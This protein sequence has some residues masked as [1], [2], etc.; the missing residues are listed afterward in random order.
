MDWARDIAIEEEFIQRLRDKYLDDR[1]GEYHYTAMHACLT[2]AYFDETDPIP[3]TRQ[4]LMFFSIGFALEQVYLR[5]DK[6]PLPKKRDVLGV[7]MSPDYTMVS[8]KDAELDLKTTRMGAEDDG[9][10]KRNKTR[11]GGWPDYWLRQFAGYSVGQILEGQGYNKDNWESFIPSYW[12][13]HVGIVYLGFPAQFVAGTLRFTRDELIQHMSRA[14]LRRDMLQMFLEQREVPTP[15]T[16]NNGDAECNAK[17]D[18]PCRYLMR[19]QGIAR[20]EQ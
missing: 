8:L 4:Q 18:S 3:L 15:F 1:R 11:P 10:P 7:M 9:S 5:D 2:K 20:E 17:G 6:T 12:D 19:C 13:Y 14:L 16:F